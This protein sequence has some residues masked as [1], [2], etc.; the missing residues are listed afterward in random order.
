MNSILK[1]LSYKEQ[2]P[3]LILNP[4]EEFSSILNEFSTQ[5]DLDIKGKYSFIQIFAV[6]SKQAEKLAKKVLKAIDDNALLWFCYPKGT[7]KKYKSDL[8]REICANLFASVNYEPVAQIAIDEDWSAMR[9]KPVDAI[10]TMKRK[11]AVSMK[12]K[13]RIAKDSKKK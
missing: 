4:P 1:K 9:F 8:K 2:N 11:N 10:K 13:K 12:G 3:V 7:S 5:V 6:E